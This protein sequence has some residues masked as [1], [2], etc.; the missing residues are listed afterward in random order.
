VKRIVHGIAHITGGG[1]IDN[2]PRILPEGCA[3]R[4]S[5]A[6]WQVPPV[7]PW[8]QN[9]GGVSDDEM[10][11]VFNMG[12][13]L[14]LIVADYYADAIARYITEEVKIP[15]WIIGEVVEG[16]RNVVWA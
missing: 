5:R 14:V 16:D 3:I 8:L 12:I 6:S 15:S 2:P 4:L 1:L 13:G 10:F 9:L 7:F 11:R